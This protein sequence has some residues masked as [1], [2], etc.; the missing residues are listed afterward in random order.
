MATNKLNS[1]GHWPDAVTMDHRQRRRRRQRPS[2][3]VTTGRPGRWA[4]A[5]ATRRR[6]AGGTRGRSPAAAGAR[7]RPRTQPGTP[8]TRAIAGIN[9]RRRRLLRHRRRRRRAAVHRRR[10][11][12]Q[13]GLV[14]PRRPAELHVVDAPLRR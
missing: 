8:R 2:P 9:R 3:A 1:I 5:A 14:Q 10:V 11:L 6:T 13:D 7:R 12:R 4:D